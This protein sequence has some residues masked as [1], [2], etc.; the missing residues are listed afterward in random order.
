[1]LAFNSMREIGERFG[2]NEFTLRADSA[3]AQLTGRLASPT[4]PA[5]SR[6]DEQPAEVAAVAHAITA[7]RVRVGLSD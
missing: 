2:L 4:L 3:L 6:V 1:M 5:S 7:M